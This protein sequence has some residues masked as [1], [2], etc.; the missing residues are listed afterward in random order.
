MSVVNRV[1]KQAM[2]SDCMKP[3][4]VWSQASNGPSPPIIDRA[5]IY[6]ARPKQWFISAN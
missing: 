4:Q 6:K 2:L 1:E 5:D 3:K